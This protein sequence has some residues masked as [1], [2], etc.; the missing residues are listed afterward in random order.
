MI[1]NRFMF[2]KKWMQVYGISPNII[3]FCSRK[4]K[5]I[6]KLNNRHINHHPQ[7]I[8]ILLSHAS[9]LIKI[10]KFGLNKKGKKNSSR[11]KGKNE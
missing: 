5:N 4:R 1:S 8:G 3:K 10:I 11:T 9:Y 7:L 2:R 6:A